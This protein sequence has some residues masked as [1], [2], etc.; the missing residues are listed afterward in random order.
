MFGEIALILKAANAT[1]V[2]V[3]GYSSYKKYRLI[4]QLE[5]VIGAPHNHR[6]QDL[7][8]TV[9][10]MTKIDDSFDIN[11]FTGTVML[12][13]SD[14]ECLMRLRRK[15]SGEQFMR[16]IPDDDPKH[17]QIKKDFFL[18]ILHQ[19]YD[20]YYQ[21]IDGVPTVDLTHLDDSHYHDLKRSFVGT[22]L[23][24][25]VYFDKFF[26][27]CPTTSMD[28][29][30]SEKRAFAKERI[31]KFVFHVVSNLDRTFYAEFL[32]EIRV[33]YIEALKVAVK[34]QEEWVDWTSKNG[35]GS[36]DCPKLD[37]SEVNYLREM[38]QELAS[39]ESL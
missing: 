19:G 16:C 33:A 11:G 7:A 25:E 18:D 13:F 29:T 21:R 38:Q 26:A 24:S 12:L 37:S 32:R 3:K 20:D 15:V 30:D 22:L 8:A 39:V 10:A 23:F 17:R 27:R 2:A 36:P 6:V 5:L 34:S 9:V 35:L 14:T 1:R 28:F 31:S 4:K